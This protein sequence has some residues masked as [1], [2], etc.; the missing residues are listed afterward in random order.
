MAGHL[1]EFSANFHP[2]IPRH[3]PQYGDIPLFCFSRFHDEL[4]AFRIG[5]ILLWN[6]GIVY[7]ILTTMEA[8]LH[9]FSSW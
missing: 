6:V 5:D 4:V 9:S 1:V 3:S 8:L 2:L 7:I